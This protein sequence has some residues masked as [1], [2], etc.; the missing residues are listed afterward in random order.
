MIF[1]PALVPR[2]GTVNINI[3]LFPCFVQTNENRPTS[4]AFIAP[5]VTPLVTGGTGTNPAI[6]L[7]SYNLGEPHLSDMEQYY[8]D[9]RRANDGGATEWRLL[10]KLSETY[11]VP[12]LSV[13]SME[14]VL[15]MLEESEVAFQTYYR[16]N[17]VAHEEGR[18][19]P[20][21]LCSVSVLYISHPCHATTF[22][23]SAI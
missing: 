19:T 14:K 20:K 8:M 3:K 23:L 4:V 2:Y 22:Q 16:F 12:D 15:L 21:K 18:S 5:S 10:Y 9:L 7:Y 17:T 11:G 1:C 13:E 6:R